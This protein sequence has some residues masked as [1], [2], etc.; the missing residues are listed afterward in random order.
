MLWDVKFAAQ[1][2]SLEPY[3]VYYLLVMGEI[4]S[5]KIGNA[6]RL[7]PEA[8]Q[9]YDKRHPDRKNRKPS[10]NFIYTGSG[11][12]LFRTLSDNIPPDSLRKTA[13]MERR[14]GQLVH[15]TKRHQGVLL[16]KLK[17]LTQLDLFSA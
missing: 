2:L 4:E 16:E 11:G 1:F 17:P 6:W 3:Q 10:G 7:T 15:R 8:V 9:D 12:F 14:R 13:R 5:V